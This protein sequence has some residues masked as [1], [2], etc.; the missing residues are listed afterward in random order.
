MGA[1]PQDARNLPDGWWKT[2]GAAKLFSIQ[3][4]PH[5]LQLSISYSSEGKT[6]RLPSTGLLIDSDGSL[7]WLT[8]GHVIEGIRGLLADTSKPV[9]D[10]RW[11][12]RYPDK[13]AQTLPVP[14]R[15]V[16]SLSMYQDRQDFGAILLTPYE[17]SILR[18]NPSLRPMPVKRAPPGSPRA[19]E[20]YILVG[21][22]WEQATVTET[23]VSSSQSSVTLTS[24]L[25]CLPLEM[26]ESPR[27]AT[28]D[29]FWDD[30]DAF[31]ARVLDYTDDPGALP[32]DLRGM[33]GGPIFSF[34]RTDQGTL[35]VSL[36]AILASYSRP[37]RE[38]RAEPIDRVINAV[39][40]WI[41][42]HSP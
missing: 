39:E 24:D 41:A 34:Y 20:G 33:S 30:Q 6:Y 13:V 4:L 16:S 18:N 5:M 19:I 15:A 9:L 2:T 21:F 3:L 27:T 1:P 28:K 37:N 14:R 40:Q 25:A 32:E 35:W 10:I 11:L 23:P 8:A 17:A 26:V 29:Q 36:V 31:Y 7:V 12:D 22:P 38:I 42:G